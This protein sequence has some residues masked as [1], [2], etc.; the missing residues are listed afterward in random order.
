MASFSF[1]IGSTSV[2]GRTLHSNASAS[3]RI[4]MF[5]HS[6]LNTLQPTDDFVHSEIMVLG[7]GGG[8]RKGVVGW[9]A[10]ALGW[11]EEIWG[12]KVDGRRRL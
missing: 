1:G 2:L 8:G 4:T 9:R 5:C 7:G 11:K 3:C 6:L 12:G 10:K